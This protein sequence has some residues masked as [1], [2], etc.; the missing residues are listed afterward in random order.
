MD[1]TN[2]GW[3]EYKQRVLYQLEALESVCNNMNK[4]ID[5]IKE[6]VTILKVKAGIYGTIGGLVMAIIF[7]LVKRRV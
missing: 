4:K 1:G 2:S 6:D 3:G 5:I 7:E